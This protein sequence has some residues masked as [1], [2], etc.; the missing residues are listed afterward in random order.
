[1]SCDLFVFAGEKSADLHGEKLL[2][3]LRAKNPAL[4]ISGVGGPRMRSQGMDCVLQMEDFQVMGFIDVFL[5]LPKLMRQF[6]FVASEIKRLNPKAVITID[7]PGFN[8]RMARHLRKKGFK[9]KLVHFICPSVWAWGKKRIPLMAENLDLLLSI[10][11]FEKELF[12]GTP[13]K[14][15][16]VGHPLSERMKTLV[17]KTPPFPLDRKIVSLFPGSRKKEIERNLPLILDVCRDL[18]KKQ[19]ELRIALSVS[20]ERFR[21]LIL[22]I[23]KEKG[24]DGKEIELVPAEYSYE[25]MKASY[26]AIAKSGTVTLELAL[27]RVPTVVI[28]GVSFLDKIIAY[29]ILRIRLP[30]YCLVNIIAQKEVFPELIGPNFTYE[31]VKAKAEMLLGESARLNIQNACDDIISQ[32]GGKETSKQA[33]SEILKLALDH[34]PC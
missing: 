23:I 32:L 1:M 15:A 5:A 10:L 6:Y 19:P 25:L 12:T 18:Q 3:A 26:L 2:Q 17:Y 24:W 22:Q 11:P 9:G 27:H 7:Y 28:Y 20:D 8:L 34:H 4:N 14:V 13:L 31:N 16:F 33:A 21:P 29:D 30:F